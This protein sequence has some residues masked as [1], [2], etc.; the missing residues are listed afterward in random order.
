[1]LVVM[2][3]FIVFGYLYSQS[4]LQLCNTLHK[5]ARAGCGVDHIA[6]TACRLDFLTFLWQYSLIQLN[7]DLWGSEPSK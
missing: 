5:M 1:M 2:I 4:N 6:Y 3:A 7:N